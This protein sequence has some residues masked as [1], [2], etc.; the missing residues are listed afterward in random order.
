M[1]CRYV[2]AEGVERTY[3]YRQQDIAAAVPVANQ[4][5][6]FDLKLEPLGPYVMDYS[7]NGR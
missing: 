4:Q 5:H 2:E 7:R 3:H 1:C 6:Y